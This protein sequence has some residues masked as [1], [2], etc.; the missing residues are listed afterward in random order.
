MINGDSTIL[1]TEHFLSINTVSWSN[2]DEIVTGGIDNC[3]GIYSRLRNYL[4]IPQA[5]EDDINSVAW[6]PSDKSLFASVSDDCLIKLWRIK[7]RD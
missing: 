3:L 5:H 4:Y 2:N 6:N 7:K 1:P